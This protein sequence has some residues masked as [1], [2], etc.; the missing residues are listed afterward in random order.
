MMCDSGGGPLC[1]FCQKLLAEGEERECTAPQPSSPQAQ[2]IE[3]PS[4]CCGRGTAEPQKIERVH[5][6]EQP[7]K[8]V[9][10]PGRL[11]PQRVV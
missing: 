5:N 1:M 3:M 7:Q 10:V 9:R 2:S 4:G 6:L 8:I 11:F